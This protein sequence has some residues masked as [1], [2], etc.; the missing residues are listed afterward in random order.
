MRITTCSLP[1]VNE[2][3]QMMQQC[4]PLPL[5]AFE[6]SCCPSSKR[7]QASSENQGAGSG[8]G[9]LIGND[10]CWAMIPVVG[11]ICAL[12]VAWAIH[13]ATG[14]IHPIA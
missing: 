11:V 6:L 7:V 2:R 13:S 5:N 8:L 14:V 1:V 9:G 3:L 12:A 10:S 4:T